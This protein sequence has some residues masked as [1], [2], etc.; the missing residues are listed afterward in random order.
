MIIQVGHESSSS[1]PCLAG[2]LTVPPAGRRGRRG[3]DSGR[4]WLAG[5]G[6]RAAAAAVTVIMIMYV[7]QQYYSYSN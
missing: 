3:R 1:C 5:V 7:I 4:P 6:V 2:A